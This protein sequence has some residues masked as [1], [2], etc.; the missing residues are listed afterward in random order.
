MAFSRKLLLVLFL[1]F[2]SPC[3]GAEFI[4]WEEAGRLAKRDGS[5]IYVLITSESCPWCDKQKDVLGGERVYLSLSG[6]LVCK[7]DARS[8]AAKRYKSRIV[9]VSMILDSDGSVVKKNAG[10]MDEGDFLSWIGR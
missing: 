4:S 5:K 1:V 10:F 8:E 3:L 9:P 7:L 2:S 6:F